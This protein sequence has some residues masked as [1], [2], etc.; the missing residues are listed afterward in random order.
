MDVEEEEEEGGGKKGVGGMVWKWVPVIGSG[1][2]DF[3][4]GAEPEAVG[5]ALLASVLSIKSPARS[6]L[7][8]EIDVSG[9][10]A[11]AA[12]AS[13][14]PCSP[15]DLSSP[16]TSSPS[17]TRLARSFSA[18]ILALASRLARAASPPAANFALPSW[19][20]SCSITRCRSC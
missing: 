2:A 8:V 20:F 6:G 15:F 3:G 4:V 14:S 13:A 12:S 10:G 19:L 18:F 7:A 11:K 17:A 5:V 16:P 9:L 1:S